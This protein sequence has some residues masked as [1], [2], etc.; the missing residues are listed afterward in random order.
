MV[1]TF[2]SWAAFDTLEIKVEVH[3]SVFAMCSQP[4]LPFLNQVF[5]SLQG[6]PLALA[7]G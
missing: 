7:G 5:I 1:I 2:D 3:F 6:P 4:L